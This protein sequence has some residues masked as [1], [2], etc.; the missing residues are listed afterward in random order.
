MDI[1]KAISTRNLSRVIELL[2]NGIDPN[3]TYGPHH[4]PILHL[5]FCSTH[6]LDPIG[7]QILNKLIEYGADIN[8]EDDLGNTVVYICVLYSKIESLLQLLMMNVNIYSVRHDNKTCLITSNL[9]QKHFSDKKYIYDLLCYADG[10]MQYIKSN[11][12]LKK[13]DIPIKAWINYL[14]KE[15][16]MEL[17]DWLGPIPNKVYNLTGKYTGYILE[18]VSNRYLESCMKLLD[19]LGIF[20]KKVYNLTGKNIGYLLEQV[21]NI[22]EIAQKINSY[23]EYEYI[24]DLRL[25]LSVKLQ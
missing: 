1:K 18:Q 11:L 12:R 16:C 21:S 6:P 25:Q 2:Q 13:F 19:W 15:S 3:T 4:C 24:S 23:I 7:F 14:S 10:N 20:P 5:L 8:K 9:Y 22:H 17:L